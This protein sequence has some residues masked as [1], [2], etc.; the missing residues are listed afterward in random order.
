MTA[1]SHDAGAVAVR[2][3]SGAGARTALRTLR[4][5]QWTKNALVFAGTLFAGKVGDGSAWGEALIAFAVYCALSSAAYV[6]NDVRDRGEDRLHPVKKLRPIASG[7]L[8]TR[9]ALVL[10]GL[11][12]AGGLLAAWSLGARS[13]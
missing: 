12:A 3:R 8:G 5:R 6:V 13:L 11:L 7:A 9:P 4:P 2:A 10:A 1:T